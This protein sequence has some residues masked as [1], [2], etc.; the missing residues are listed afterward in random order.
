[1]LLQNGRTIE[2]EQDRRRFPDGSRGALGELLIG[3]KQFVDVGGMNS[4][5]LYWGGEDLDFHIRVCAELGLRRKYLGEVV[6]LTHGDK[7]RMLLRASKA[8]SSD[9]NLAVAYEQYSKGNFI[10]TLLQDEAMYTPA[11][12]FVPHS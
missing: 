1:L 2:F 5:L 8:A 3:R 4:R 9:F 11:V 12:R 10:G 6:H 7:T